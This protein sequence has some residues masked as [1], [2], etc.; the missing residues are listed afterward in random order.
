MGFFVDS[1]APV[2]LG[3]SVLLMVLGVVRF[4][5]RFICLL[6]Y[7]IKTRILFEVK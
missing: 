5:K 4:L 3:P 1:V 7:H 6:A 2:H